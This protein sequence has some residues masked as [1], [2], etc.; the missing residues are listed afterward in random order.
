M[1]GTVFRVCKLAVVVGLVSAAS[2]AL[3]R[4]ALY[5]PQFQRALALVPTDSAFVWLGLGTVAG[6]F[7]GTVAVLQAPTRRPAFDVSDPETAVASDEGVMQRDLDERIERLRTEG[8]RGDLDPAL[9]FEDVREAAV[10]LVADAYQE[11]P[12][13]AR[14]RIESGEWTDDAYAAAV[15]SPDPEFRPSL[16]TRVWEWFLGDRAAARRIG[17]V[18]RALLALAE[19]DRQREGD[20]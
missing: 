3:L 2:T 5:P 8:T 7:A 13:Q 9:L 14:A 17:R 16:L 10:P 19:R 4:P 6:L 12:E 18:E 15:L 11:R 20:G 1:I